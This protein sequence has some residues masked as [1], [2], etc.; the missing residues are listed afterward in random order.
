M[1]ENFENVMKE[2]MNYSD[3]YFTDNVASTIRDIPFL[4]RAR[5]D[6][7][8]LGKGVYYFLYSE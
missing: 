1:F 2:H 4:N 7:Y 5:R 6:S 8:F 3:R